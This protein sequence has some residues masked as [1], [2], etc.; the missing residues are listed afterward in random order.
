MPRYEYQCVC[1]RAVV[2]VFAM[3]EF[4]GMVPCAGCGGEAKRIFAAPQLK[5][6]TL[7]S[8]ANKRGLAELDSTRRTDEAAYA[9]NW[10][11]PLPIL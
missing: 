11:R 10:D 5:R 8:E 6:A 9:R 3:R 7:F 4:P 2:R 1:G